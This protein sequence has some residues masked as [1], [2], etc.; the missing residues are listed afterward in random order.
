MDFLAGPFID[1]EFLRLSLVA[2]C[3][4]AVTCAVAGAFVVLRGLSFVG[5]A[6]AHGV[7]PGVAVA[8]LVGFSGVLGAAIGAGVMMAGVGVVNRRF[9]LSGDTSI[10]LLFVGML[11]LGVIIQSRSSSF[12]G[13]LTAVLFGEV[14]GASWVDI[15]WQVVALIV[16]AATAWVCRRPFLLLSFDEGLAATSGFSVRRY[17][18]IMLAMVALTV[19]ASFQTVGTLLVLGMLVAPAATGALYGRRIST[20]VAVAAVVGV[21]SSYVG[22]LVSYHADLAAGASIVLTA[23]VV[24]ALCATSIELRRWWDHRQDI[25]HLHDHPHFHE[26]VHH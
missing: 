20:V 4:V 25:H 11:A 18:N 3:I 13:D 5:D 1:N 17:G 9:R 12:A 15:A 16:V 6:L 7:V 10:G 2:T 24:F 26:H 19:V 23:V 8:L 14:L 21:A 22:L